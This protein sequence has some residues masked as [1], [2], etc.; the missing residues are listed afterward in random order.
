MR[1][2]WQRVHRRSRA[3][4]LDHKMRRARLPALFPLLLALIGVAVVACGSEAER[5]AVHFL[6]ADGTID[7]IMARYID[8]GIDDAESSEAKLLVIELDT[9]GGLNESMRDIVRRIEASTVPIAVYVSPS[10]GRAAS[11][12]TFI[13]M[14]AH[15]AAMAPNTSIGAASAI[16]SDGSD[17]EGTLGAKI[18]NDAVALI[19]GSAESRGRN[20]DWA[21]SAVRDAIA[22]TATEAAE[23][24]VVDFVASDRND[25]LSQAD[26]RTISLAG[27]QQVELSGLLDTP[28]VDVNMTVWE[29]FLSVIAN[30]TIASLL[31]SVAFF[32][33]I[34]EMANPGL[35]FP[36]LIGG[37]SLALGFLGFDIL[38]VN[39]IGIILI[40]MALA[41]FG[42]ELVVPSG[43]MLGVAGVVA[44]ILGVIIA[45]RDTP[46]EFRPPEWLGLVLGIS[47]LAV[48]LVVAVAM[49]RV[50][51]WSGAT[52]TPLLVG[53]V[54]VARTRIDPKGLIFIQGEQWKA[55]ADAGPIPEGAKVRIL[56]ANGSTLRVRREDAP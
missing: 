39:T 7:P 29:R 36:G 28:V 23:L 35:M 37:I 15:I 25:L 31:L 40:I 44:M 2:N 47:V 46:S 4:I 12:G 16:N 3:G 45:F 50:I 1:S 38:P 32:G 18:E 53:K 6:E 30:P 41:F 56:E 13:T 11:A 14:A 52:S 33:I 55:K 43:G 51:N 48:F 42:L 20:A 24:N 21:E 27:G 10:G 9:P 26:G 34:I 5:G 17:I 54:A 49:A 22:S 19:R 8:R